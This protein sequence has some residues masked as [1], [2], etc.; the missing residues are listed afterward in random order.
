MTTPSRPSWTTV[1]G[2]AVGIGICSVATLGVWLQ[3]ATSTF[4]A[5]TAG[6][7]SL[8]VGI[9]VGGAWA[10]LRPGATG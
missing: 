1:A 4:D 8:A 3:Y 6:L 7:L 9:V 5:L 10:L 2:Y